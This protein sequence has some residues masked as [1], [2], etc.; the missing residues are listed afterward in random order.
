[1]HTFQGESCT[2]HYNS[3]MSGDLHII[4]NA[5]NTD[6]DIKVTVILK[7]GDILKFVAEYIRS[8]RIGEIESKDWEEFLK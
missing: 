4:A 3:D 7:A 5:E 1:M 2:I 6:K 8:E